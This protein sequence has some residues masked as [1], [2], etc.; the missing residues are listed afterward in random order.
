MDRPKVSVLCCTHEAR[1]PFLPW[2]FW[3]F[4]KQSLTGIELVLIDSGT[5][6]IKIYSDTDHH[7][8]H[9]RFEENHVGKKYE[10][11]LEL[12]RGE[13]VMLWADDDWHHPREL[14]VAYEVLKQGVDLS[15]V[16]WREGWYLDIETLRAARYRAPNRR[17]CASMALVKLEHARRGHFTKEVA[18]DTEWFQQIED[19]AGVHCEI[20]HAPI[21]HVLWLVHGGNMTPHLKE[22]PWDST[23]TEFGLAQRW[24]GM[25]RE[26]DALK[27]RLGRA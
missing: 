4:T 23:L 22:L 19:G 12:A 20:L 17:P 10:L 9:H 25:R 16:G 3:N 27:A 18:S 13:T 11:A 6:D 2:L 15:Y 1:R 26:L 14:E 8:R 24:S 5:S 7:V 21:P